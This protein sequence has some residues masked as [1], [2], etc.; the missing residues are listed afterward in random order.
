MP[1]LEA[2]SIRKAYDGVIALRDGSLTCEEGKICGL[3]GANGSGK[4]TMSK[5]LSGVVRPDAGEILVNGSKVEFRSPRHASQFG[6]AMVHQHLSLIPEL[7]VWENIALGH[8]ARKRGG[9]L[10]DG[11][12]RE[13]AEQVVRELCPGI[14]IYEKVSRL[15]PAQRQLIEIT[16][17]ISLQ[18]KILI[19]DEP[20]AALEYAEVERLCQKLFALKEHGVSTI[21]IS[22]RLWEVTRLCD[23]AVVFRNGETVG[24][25]DFA[26][27]GVDE[28]TIVEMITGKASAQHVRTRAVAVTRPAAKPVLEVRQVCVRNVLKEINLSLYPGEIVGLSG[29]HGQGQ[30]A[31]LMLLSG[32]IP[33]TSGE[34]RVDGSRIRLKHPRDAIRH[35]MM[36]VPGDRHKEGLFLSHSVFNNLVYPGFFRKRAQRILRRKRLADQVRNII[37]MTALVPSN[38]ERPVKT[39]SGGNQQKVVIGKWLPLEPKIL[40]LSDPAKGVDVQAKQD[41]YGIVRELAGRGTAVLL[42]ASDYDELIPLCDR[43]L[44]MFEG[45]IVNELPAGA[46]SRESVIVAGLGRGTMVRS[47]AHGTS[48]VAEGE[49]APL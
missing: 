16:K 32:L 1:V 49:G 27:G 14:S 31:L 30:E 43:V 39:L 10:D 40:L 7:T 17:V 36:L 46:L 29:L 44:V 35:G 28:Q 33:L 45:R 19:L 42:Y 5:I 3:L 34:I 12:S 9:F 21:F 37:D 18:P 8:E 26:G 25:I 22:H 6:I 38:P 48:N 41:L 15:S 24:R 20:T 11:R 23:Y 2:R 47:P 13:R 4:S